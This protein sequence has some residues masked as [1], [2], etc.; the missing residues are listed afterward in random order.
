M[1]IY[2]HSYTAARTAIN[3]PKGG[4]PGWEALLGSSTSRILICCGPKGDYLIG[5]ISIKPINNQFLLTQ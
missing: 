2:Q 1:Y 4:A 5:L 3:G